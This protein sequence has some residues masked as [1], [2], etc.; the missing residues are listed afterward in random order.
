MRG[1]TAVLLLSVPA[2][3]E[4]GRPRFFPTRD[5]AVTY[6]VSGP[7]TAGT[8]GDV[9]RIADLAAERK[10]RMDASP[11]SWTVIE[12]ATGTGLR[13]DDGSRTA[14]RVPLNP[15]VMAQFGPPE[16]ASLTR[17][18]EERVAGL[19]CTGWAYRSDE[20]SGRF[21]V[22]PEALP[23]RMEATIGGQTLRAE[24]AEV[25]LAPQD[26]ARFRI[27]SGYQ[28]REAVP[29]RGGRR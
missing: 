18:R 17:E 23:L 24:A 16:H 7:A 9:L 10:Q 3:A 11:G 15:A 25:S 27:P 12:R 22:T 2:I 1:V 21:C 13:V 19:A 5:A 20:G 29:P 6:R 28:V 14:L 26:P 4:D 8:D